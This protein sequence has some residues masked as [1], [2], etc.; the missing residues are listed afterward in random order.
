MKYLIDS[1][2]IISQGNDKVLR[3]CIEEISNIK[4]RPLGFQLETL[5]KAPIPDC[6]ESIQDVLVTGLIELCKV[7]PVGVD[8]VQWLGEWLLNNNPSKP[9]VIEP[10]E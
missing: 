3:S 10:S 4:E 5:V 8:A 9:V 7:K 1:I 6:T 2:D